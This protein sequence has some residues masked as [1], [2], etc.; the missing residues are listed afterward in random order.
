MKKKEFQ[1]NVRNWIRVEGTFSLMI[2]PH[3]LNRIIKLWRDMDIIQ[4][5]LFNSKFYLIILLIKQ[6]KTWMWF[7]KRDLYEKMERNW[8]D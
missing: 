7:P 3:L 5:K 8:I 4:V 6:E 2:I 1:K